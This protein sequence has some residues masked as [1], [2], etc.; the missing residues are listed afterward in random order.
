M[1]DQTPFAQSEGV[2]EQFYGQGREQQTEVEIPPVVKKFSL[3]RLWRYFVVAPRMLWFTLRMPA[4]V[5]NAERI[6]D[7]D[8]ARKTPRGRSQQQSDEELIA[9]VE[10]DIREGARGRRRA[11][12]G[13]GPDRLEL[14][15]AARLHEELARR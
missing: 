8:R 6:V 9:M 3:G 11:R 14:R 4:D 5:R 12:L 7:E 1:I 2:I 10:K 13:R 15:D